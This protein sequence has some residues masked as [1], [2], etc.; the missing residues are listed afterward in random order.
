MG[1]RYD[2]DSYL[3][4]W[5]SKREYP[6]IH[7]NMYELVTAT[8]TSKTVMDL[9]CSTGLLGQHVADFGANVIGVEALQKSIDKAKSFGIEIPLIQL[10]IDN[11]SID[12]L[13]EIIANNSVTGIIARRCLSE[14]F[15]TEDKTSIDFKWA[16]L[17]TKKIVEAGIKEIWVEGRA[18]Q[19]RSVHPIPNTETEIVCLESLFDV[20]VMRNRCA[21]LEA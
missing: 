12:V 3:E 19:G 9:C 15:V 2:D 17:F 4:A 6:K 10:N 11:N 5:Q 7:K 13:C 16:N 21:K 8:I 18:E 1:R 20:V 14:L